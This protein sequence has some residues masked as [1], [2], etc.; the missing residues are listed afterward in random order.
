MK[1]KHMIRLGSA[2]A[3]SLAPFTASAYTGE[4]A[5]NACAEAF[6]AE[7][8]GEEIAWRLDDE[9]DVGGRLNGSQILHLDARDPKTNEVVARADC[10]VDSRARIKRLTTVPVDAK[11][12]SERALTAY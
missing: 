11:D 2:L 5:M 10:V 3:L 6:T 7:I 8:T 4:S 12:A 9:S 1:T